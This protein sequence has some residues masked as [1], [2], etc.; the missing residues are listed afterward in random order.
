MDVEREYGLASGS[1]LVLAIVLIVI[2]FL[3]IGT[4]APLKRAE[5]K[6][7]DEF[8]EFSDCSAKVL[9]GITSSKTMKVIR[10]SYR[11]IVDMKAEDK[12]SQLHISSSNGKQYHVVSKEPNKVKKLIESNSVKK[13]KKK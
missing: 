5:I 11:D 12:R 7:Y 4:I 3:V 8:M 1:Q 2:G 13:H 10:L 6:L 9:L